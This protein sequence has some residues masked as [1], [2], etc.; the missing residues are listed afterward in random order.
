MFEC[1]TILAPPDDCTPGEDCNGNGSWDICDITDGTSEDC[2]ENDIPDECDLD[3]T[4]PDGD[5][6]VSDDCNGNGVPDDCDIAGGSSDDCNRNGSPDECDI[7]SGFSEDCNGNGV[8][9]ECEPDCNG[10]G[11]Q[12]TC[13]IDSG[14]SEDCNG[15][16]VPDECEGKFA[17]V[18]NFAAG[19]KPRSIAI[20]DLDGDQVP[21]LAVA[22]FNSDNVSVLLNQLGGCNG[23]GIPDECDI[24]CG[25][26][27]G[28]CDRP[29]CGQSEDCNGNG[30][31]DDCEVDTDNDGVIDDCD[32][33]LDSDLAKLIVLEEC[34]TGV[35]NELLD[36]GCTMNDVLTECSVGAHNHG[37]WT[38]CVARHANVWR[39]QGLL[40]G[41]DIGRITHCAGTSS[42][43]TPIQRVPSRAP[44]GKR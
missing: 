32:A 37:E 18:V 5:G 42:R 23:N 9:D 40:S 4:D 17:P 22:N 15:N 28:A 12:D 29:G 2:N 6:F 33:C 34:P 19:A 16:G 13:D 44:H 3:P 31:P 11:I 35:P 14:F 43:D 7:D 30:E 36:D 20:G 26:P 39:R 1:L 24:D 27:G 41:K 10:N 8:P 25:P 21:D 38:A